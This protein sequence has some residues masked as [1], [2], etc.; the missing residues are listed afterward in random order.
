MQKE[1]WTH[2]GLQC[3]STELTSV[4]EF[5]P[6]PPRNN[7]EGAAKTIPGISFWSSVWSPGLQEDVGYTV[8][9]SLLVMAQKVTVTQPFCHNRKTG[10][11]SEANIVS[12]TA[13]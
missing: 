11:T 6:R 2:P 13:T 3:L 12:D 4:H 8:S 7:R 1:K 5:L 10:W 9:F